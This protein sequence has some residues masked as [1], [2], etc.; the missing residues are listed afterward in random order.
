MRTKMP[1]AL[2]RSEC[3]ASVHE[4]DMLM[5]P[6]PFLPEMWH[7]LRMDQARHEQHVLMLSIKLCGID[8]DYILNKFKAERK[9]KHDKTNSMDSDSHASDIAVSAGAASAHQQPA[10][11]HANEHQSHVVIGHK[12]SGNGDGAEASPDGGHPSV[13]PARSEV[14]RG[15]GR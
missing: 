14:D 3:G 1:P 6:Y 9:E 5:P 4:H 11:N 13:G 15:Q 10:I 8:P 2:R 7:V 12:D